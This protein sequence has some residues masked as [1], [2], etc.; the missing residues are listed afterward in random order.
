LIDLLRRQRGGGR[1]DRDIVIGTGLGF[2]LS[3]L[4]V[5]LGEEEKAIR[6]R[7]GN[8]GGLG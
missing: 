4:L 5:S 7:R 1:D 6:C 8:I 3:K 2:P